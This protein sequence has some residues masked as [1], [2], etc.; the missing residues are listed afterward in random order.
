MALAPDDADRLT[1]NA[2]ERVLGYV[3]P[4]AHALA[5]KAAARD[6]T[7]VAAALKM[8]LGAEDAQAVQAAV[9]GRQGPSDDESSSGD[10]SDVDAPAWA[11]QQDLDAALEAFDAWV[12]PDGAERRAAQDLFARIEGAVRRVDP[13][14]DVQLRG[15]RRS[16]CALFD[17]DLDVVVD[18][19]RLDAVADAL[20]A[21][22]WSRG[23]ELIRA[24]VP[25][26]RRGV[27]RGGAFA[28]MPLTARC[29]AGD[30]QGRDD[31]PRLRR[32][33]AQ[34]RRAPGRARVRRRRHRRRLRARPAAP[35]RGH[36]APLQ[37]RAAADR[38]RGR[39][40]GR[41]VLLRA[42]R[43]GLRPLAAR[44]A[45]HAGRGR[46][47]R[48]TGARRREHLRAVRSFEWR[49]GCGY[50]PRGPG[51]RRGRVRAGRRRRRAQSRRRF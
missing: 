37:G 12:R 31:A 20:H 16:D 41:A 30:R 42:L 15:S 51:R 2:L 26:V 32:R 28:S 13:F 21:A 49:R 19:V 50:K 9:L 27:A 33:D 14:A 38:A 25:I 7:T 10:E 24:R 17:A 3:D 34:G 39:L 22:E 4:V 48:V 8:V 44:F 45:E 23:A 1:E 6:E 43:F 36:G 47:Q 35:L 46:G 40:R 5:S 29:Y 18:D 11:T